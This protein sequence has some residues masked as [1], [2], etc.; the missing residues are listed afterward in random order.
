MLR[1]EIILHTLFESGVSKVQE[2]ERFISDDVERY[3]ARLLDMEKKLVGV[4][5][6]VVSNYIP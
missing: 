6:D 2:L 5:R 1:Q 4:Y 3:G